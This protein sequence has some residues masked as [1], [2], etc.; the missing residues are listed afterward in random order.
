MTLSWPL[1]ERRASDDGTGPWWAGP[2]RV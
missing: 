1:G 2:V